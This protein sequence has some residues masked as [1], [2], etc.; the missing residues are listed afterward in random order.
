MTTLTIHHRT[1]Y[2]YRTPMA[3]GPHRLMLRPRESRTLRLHAHELTVTPEAGLTWA[4]DVVS[5]SVA[6]ASIAAPAD[7]LVID[8]LAPDARRRSVAGL[9]H[10]RVGGAL[11][12]LL[13]RTGTGAV[14]GLD[15]PS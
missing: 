14:S 10:R 15:N 6:T 4:Q 2:R 8:S 12:A 11:S 3:F 5:N 7:S 13:A 1:T 9:P